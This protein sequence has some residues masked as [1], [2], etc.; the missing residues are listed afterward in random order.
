MGAFC[1]GLQAPRGAVSHCG[2]G[3][4]GGGGDRV[5]KTHILAL[6]LDNPG[7]MLLLI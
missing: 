1:L 6:F 3:G 2:G 5:L 7:K 4:G